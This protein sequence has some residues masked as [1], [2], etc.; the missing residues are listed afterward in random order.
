MEQVRQEL[1]ARVAA[2]GEEDDDEGEEE[3][4]E[5]GKPA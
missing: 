5:K 2:E 3:I 4:E 1:A